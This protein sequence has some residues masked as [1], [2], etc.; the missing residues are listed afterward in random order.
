MKTRTLL[1]TTLIASLTFVSVANAQLVTGAGAAGG[2]LSGGLS[3]G[4]I[5][6]AANG[7]VSGS[8][9]VDATGTRQ[10]VKRDVTRAKDRAAKTL[11]KSKE[12][13]F[14]TAEA[15]K[16]KTESSAAS[17]ES[18]TDAA[19]HS[20]VDAGASVEKS[21]LGAEQNGNNSIAVRSPNKAAVDADTSTHGQAA[22]QRSNKGVNAEASTSADANVSATH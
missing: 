6:G 9:D 1:T 4:G 16:N 14:S 3:R 8:F 17:I 12:T 5:N 20:A 7:N 11:D 21:S 15:A 2:A 13:T 19:A 18:R 22:A 10:A